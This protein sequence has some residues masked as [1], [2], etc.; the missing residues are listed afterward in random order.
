MEMLYTVRV[1]FVRFLVVFLKF[2]SPLV[3]TSKNSSL[4]LIVSKPTLLKAS[5]VILG[6]FSVVPYLGMEVI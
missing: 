1:P 4:Q 6:V 3:D 2:I 5:S